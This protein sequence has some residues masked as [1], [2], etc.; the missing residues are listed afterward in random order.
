MMTG[1]N[2]LVNINVEKLPVDSFASDFNWR[3]GLRRKHEMQDLHF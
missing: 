3:E 1:K 2:W